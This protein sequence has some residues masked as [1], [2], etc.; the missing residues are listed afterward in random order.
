MA[1]MLSCNLD[2]SPGGNG[3]LG[4]W[5]GWHR[6]RNMAAGRS[7][8]V[9]GTQTKRSFKGHMNE[10]EGSVDDIAGFFHERLNMQRILYQ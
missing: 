6:G 4:T 10:R 7:K 5:R 8:M 3:K 9:R 2:F 1:L